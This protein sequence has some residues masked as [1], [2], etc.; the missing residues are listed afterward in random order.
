LA[1]HGLS[2]KEIGNELQLSEGT[3]GW[4][5]E[6]IFLKWQVYSP[7]ALTMRV[8]KATSAKRIFSDLPP[9]ERQGCSNLPSAA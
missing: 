7:G 4:H 8:L 6:G 1:A 5:L 3:I 2:D 9:D